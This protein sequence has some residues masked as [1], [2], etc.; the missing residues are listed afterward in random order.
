MWSALEHLNVAQG[1]ALS[2]AVVVAVLIGQHVVDSTWGKKAKL[3]GVY[4]PP[5]T[6]PFL[7]NTLDVVNQKPRF[8]HWI[9]EQCDAAG[10]KAWLMTIIG[11]PLNF[12]ISTQQG[13]EDLF[14]DKA[15]SFGKGEVATEALKDFLGD[16]IIAVDG[17][18]WM[19]QRK[20]A[21]NLFSMQMLRDVMDEVI[22]ERTKYLKKML[23]EAM[24][25]G[26]SVEFRRL[27]AQLTSDVF[28]KV[29]FGVDMKSLE[30]GESD[31]IEAITEDSALAQRRFQVPRW[32]WKLERFLNIGAEA[33]IR[34]NIKTVDAL[35]HKIIMDS[36]A[37]KSDPNAPKQRDLVSLFMDTNPTVEEMHDM[38][39][40]FFAAGKDTTSTAIAWFMVMMNRYPRVA[41]KLRQEMKVQM[42]D[43]VAGDI[44]ALRM[45]ELHKLPYL[46]ACIKESLRL[47]GGVITRTALEDVTLSD[48]TFV[49]EG[50]A[51]VI[52][53]YAMG[54]RKET[55]G[56]DAEEFIPERWI[57]E[58]TGKV[59]PVS[60][61][62]FMPFLA[63][64]RQCLGM[65]FAMLEMKTVIAM[66]LSQ[67]ELKTERDPHTYT[68]EMSF[69]FPVLG[70]LNL[71]V[72]KP[73]IA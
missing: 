10:G 60:P 46:E 34:K 7:G 38:A 65:R 69:V 35:Y 71:S 27:I 63:G 58:A 8:H 3:R 55:W 22:L 40:N 17:H 31:F 11:S 20:I 73:T 57:D 66:L 12:I 28:G 59:K 13:A 21:S 42:P 18:K 26:K 49:P 52:S 9:K 32:L 2:F 16:G 37:R 6:L 14:R 70:P 1:A 36:M 33:R 50:S 5:T 43:L 15:D 19:V 23:D 56:E 39:S 64:A 41:N 68:Y 29:G 30:N 53:I 47:N 72:S 25:A 44:D 54:R 67:F 62:K 51:M 4:R 24:A 61:F 45:E 48:G